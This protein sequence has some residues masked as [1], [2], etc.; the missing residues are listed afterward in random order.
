M[1]VNTFKLVGRVGGAGQFQRQSA[2]FGI[3]KAS[4]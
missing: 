3:L 2:H 4:G 1:A